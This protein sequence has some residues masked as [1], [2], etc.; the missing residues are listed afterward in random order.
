MEVKPE[1]NIRLHSPGFWHWKDKPSEHLVLNLTTGVPKGLEEIDT[2]LLKDTHK[3]SHAP[4]LRAK[5][6]I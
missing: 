2:S 1:P 5:A 3:I 4:G 6:I